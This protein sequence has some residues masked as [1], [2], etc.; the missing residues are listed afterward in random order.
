MNKQTRTIG[1]L[2]LTAGLLAVSVAHSSSSVLP[3]GVAIPFW[4]SFVANSEQTPNPSPL[5]TGM[6]GVPGEAAE[7]IPSTS[8]FP[9]TVSQQ[10]II[11]RYRNAF[12][13]FF[14]GSPSNGAGQGTLPTQIAPAFNPSTMPGEQ[15]MPGYSGSRGAGG[16]VN[17]QSFW[18]Q[19][20]PQPGASSGNGN[21]GGFFQEPVH[22]GPTP[23]PQGGGCSTLPFCAET[24]VQIQLHCLG[25]SAI[26]DPATCGNGGNFAH[27]NCPSTGGSAGGTGGATGSTGTS[28]GATGTTGGVSGGA[29]GTTGGAGGTSGGSTGGATGGSGGDTGG[30]GGSG[31]GANPALCAN[32]ETIGVWDGTEEQ[33]HEQCVVDGGN[34]A[35][36]EM[37]WRHLFQGDYPRFYGAF[38]AL[39]PDTRD[40]YF[41]ASV[42]TDR[43]I[44]KVDGENFSVAGELPLTNIVSYDLNGNESYANMISSIIHSGNMY[45]LFDVS[46]QSLTNP[47]YNFLLVRVRLSDFRETGRLPIN[48]QGPYAS[49]AGVAVDPLRNTLLLGGSKSLLAVDL[50]SFSV[51]STFVVDH[52]GREFN[53]PAS[54]V[55]DRD[56]KYAYVGGAGYVLQLDLERLAF[57]DRIDHSIGVQSLLYD[58]ERNELYVLGLRRMLRLRL[59]PDEWRLERAGI[60]ELRISEFFSDAFEGGEFLGINYST[61]LI[62]VRMHR[63]LSMAEPMHIFFI[64]RNSLRVRMDGRVFVPQ[65]QQVPPYSM[66]YSMYGFSYPGYIDENRNVLVIAASRNYPNGPAIVEVDLEKPGLCVQGRYAALDETATFE[67]ACRADRR[68]FEAA[69]RSTDCNTDADCRAFQFDGITCGGAVN[70]CGLARAEA[71]AAELLSCTTAN[72][73]SAGA[74]GGVCPDNYDV[75]CHLRPDF[76]REPDDPKGFC[77]RANPA[78][79][80][81]RCGNGVLESGEQCD[82]GAGNGNIAASFCTKECTEIQASEQCN[83]CTRRFTSYECTEP[84]VQI[85]WNVPFEGRCVPG[86]RCPTPN[87]PAP[88]E[89]KWQTRFVDDE[90]YRAYGWFS[91]G[92][93]ALPKDP[94]HAGLSRE[95]ITELECKKANLW[96]VAPELGTCDFRCYGEFPPEKFYCGVNQVN[97]DIR[98]CRTPDPGCTMT[99]IEA[100]NIDPVCYY[101]VCRQ[102]CPLPSE[103][104]LTQHPPLVS[105]PV[106]EQAANMMYNNYAT[107]TM[108][109]DTRFMAYSAYGD[110]RHHFID[111]QR[112][113]ERYPEDLDLP[114]PPETLIQSTRFEPYSMYNRTDRPPVLIS[115]DGG[116]ATYKGIW[117]RSAPP[118]DA[119]ESTDGHGKFWGTL[120]F[121]TNTRVHEKL[122]R[123]IVLAMSPDAVWFVLKVTPGDSVVLF[124]RVTGQEETVNA[125]NFATFNDMADGVMGVR[126]DGREILYKINESV[127]GETRTRYALYDTQTKTLKTLLESTNEEKVSGLLFRRDFGLFLYNATTNNKDPLGDNHVI[128]MEFDRSAG[129]RRPVIVSRASVGVYDMSDDGSKIIIGARLAKARSMAEEQVIDRLSTVWFHDRT[130]GTF[131]HLQHLEN[132]QP[133]VG[134]KTFP[135]EFRISP[136]GNHLLTI[137]RGM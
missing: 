104:F 19:F 116:F 102:Q 49:R 29:T 67:N 48:R 92:H 69:A 71:A 90:R 2:T 28:A 31:G 87:R 35:H 129:V 125:A 97:L 88:E 113:P 14:S 61:G 131:V 124:N 25:Q 1:V 42:G 12:G 8:Q 43:K 75:V 58:E 83:D 33:Y 95:Q 10:G 36:W 70:A 137:G 37:S 103:E 134:Y 74:I 82:A 68:E 94:A 17:A 86:P 47:E 133:V 132:G 51:R 112:D 81:P 135:Y 45:L 93:C 85:G 115:A 5:S 32:P 7:N 27:C 20:V 15:T 77:G 23:E 4:E 106:P 65:P 39:D 111:R 50:N 3:G 60:M 13:N 101:K 114:P 56:R 72:P 84:C 110:G 52:A 121:N 9:T 123:G 18:S 76:Q 100:H 78:V 136:D 62:S 30:T 122:H 105:T 89:G 128:P 120:L 24:M 96:P 117:Y 64:D 130:Q 21:S 26:I 53:T 127:G 63:R 99:A 55:I 40:F 108:S 91:E 59:T 80:K 6:A 34:T 22:S 41:L 126:S 79:S 119:T 118:A 107:F 44:L 46:R 57:R 54:I 11:D 16:G 98:N 73:R 109:D 66:E 38:A